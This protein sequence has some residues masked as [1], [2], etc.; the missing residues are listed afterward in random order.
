MAENHFDLIYGEI[1][2]TTSEKPSTSVNPSKSKKKEVFEKK[3]P[4]EMP[5]A[6]KRD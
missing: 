6:K 5:P 1:F 3:L 2:G 4:K